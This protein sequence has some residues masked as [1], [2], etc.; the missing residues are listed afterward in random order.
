MSIAIK[1][2]ERNYYFVFLFLI[3]NLFYQH[4]LYA[5]TT[6]FTPEGRQ[7]TA[8]TPNE[9]SQED[10]EY[11]HWYIW[12]YYLDSDYPYTY[13]LNAVRIGNASSTYNCHGYAWSLSENCEKVWIQNDEEVKYFSDGAWSNDGQPSYLTAS[14][15]EATHS[16]YTNQDHSVRKIQNSYPAVISGSRNYVSKWGSCGLYQHEKNHDCYYLK[17]NLGH[18]FKKLKTTH[19]GTLSNYPKRWIGAGGKI[20]NISNNVTLFKSLA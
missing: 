18:L 14:E 19:Y 16:W 8:Y 10:I 7:V 6:I 12:Y 5:Q 4:S 13:N 2:I 9:M 17:Q 1:K 3:L 15:S 20:H 11:C